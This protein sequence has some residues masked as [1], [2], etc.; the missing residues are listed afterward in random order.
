MIENNRFLRKTILSENLKLFFLLTPPFLFLQFFISNETIDIALPSKF[1][2]WSLIN[3]VV[4]LLGFKISLQNKEDFSYVISRPLVVTIFCYLLYSL[5]SAFHSSN[6]NDAIY[7]WFKIFLFASSVLFLSIIFLKEKFFV[8]HVMFLFILFNCLLIVLGFWEF[9]NTARSVGINHTT[10]YM[11]TGKFGNK[12]V[13]SEILFLSLPFSAYWFF[14]SSKFKKWF[15]VLFVGLNIILLVLLLTR[16]VWLAFVLG[17]ITFLVATLSIEKTNIFKLGKVLGLSNRIKQLFFIVLGFVLLSA[18]IYSSFDKS[19]AL[20]K[21][22][23]SFTAFKSGSGKERMELSKKTIQLFKENPIVG[24]GLASWKIQVLAYGYSGLDTKNL[25]VFHQRPHNDYLWVLS[26]QGVVGLFLWMA[27]LVTFFVAIFGSAKQQTVTSKR[28]FFLLC[29]FSLSGY[30]IYSFFSF[31]KERIEH[32][33]MLCLFAVCTIVL[34]A[35]EKI[36]SVSKYLIWGFYLVFVMVSLVCCFFVF[37]RY[38][39]EKQL[40]KALQ[41]RANENWQKVIEYSGMAEHNYCRIDPMN[42][43]VSFYS[44]SASLN[45][46]NLEGAIKDFERAVIYHPNHVHVLNNL[47]SCFELKGNH[48]NAIYYFERAL[49]LCPEFQDSRMNLCAATFNSGKKKAALDLLYTIVPDTIN[50][51]YNF[52]MQTVLKSI[53]LD[54]TNSIQQED[55]NWNIKAIIN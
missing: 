25:T 15:A 48:Q 27:F 21:Q 40:N 19:S 53:L 7:E 33:L 31:P 14:S 24:C 46:N 50:P 42:T 10:L 20:K 28:I 49:L 3:L 55:F 44:A 12:N 32:Q 6:F 35:E 38:L 8:E 13:F 2:G 36:K 4:L 47:G 5:F 11:V 39:G 43:P 51:R 26:E 37:H 52:I 18:V 9:F 1:L 34:P 30:L 45:L 22:L 23:V 41:F 17:S 16:A 54:L 29:I